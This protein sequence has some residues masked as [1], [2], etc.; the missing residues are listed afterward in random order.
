MDVL[1]RNPVIRDNGNYL[2][3]FKI[4]SEGFPLLKFGVRF[5]LRRGKSNICNW[6][7]SWGDWSLDL[8]LQFCKLGV[9]RSGIIRIPLAGG[10][11]AVLD[12]ADYPLVAPYTWCKR[13]VRNTTYVQASVPG[14]GKRTSVLMHRLI[15]GAKRGEIV[16]HID[17]DGLNNRRSNLR[18]CSHSQN[19]C[20]SRKPSTNVS[21]YKGV[22]F[23]KRDQSW[24]T[25]IVMNQ[26]ATNLGNFIDL[27]SA[28]K[29]RREAERRLHG[30][31]ARSQA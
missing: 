12:A 8:G 5:Q 26:K 1:P 31:F 2:L 22:Y 19:M 4:F 28:I 20:N 3:H 23:D 14:D 18:K 27:E 6:D 24:R 9:M 13:P 25:R 21:G 30:E 29:A 7:D 16:D 17:G 11:E 10:L 15:L